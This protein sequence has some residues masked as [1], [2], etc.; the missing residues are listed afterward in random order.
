MNMGGVLMK[1]YTLDKNTEFILGYKVKNGKIHI[2]Y[3]NKKKGVVKHSKDKEEMILAKME[4]QVLSSKTERYKKSC[5]ERGNK[6]LS[7]YLIL[8]GAALLAI[9]CSL[10]VYLFPP[11]IISISVGL[12][13]AIVVFGIHTRLPFIKVNDIKKNKFFID[14]KDEINEGIKENE[15]DL[16]SIL[17][18]TK[19][20]TR[21]LVSERKGQDI[22]F[23]IN[24][25]DSLSYSELIKLRDNIRRD[26]SFTKQEEEKSNEM[27]KK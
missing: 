9:C 23:D 10:A 11:A 18:N 26:K 24:V 8:S 6:N 5:A 25:V 14:N 21:K 27:V 20:K 1:N 15:N 3:A 12:V 2:K 17:V 22:P 16:T 4:D 7:A 13:G 19:N